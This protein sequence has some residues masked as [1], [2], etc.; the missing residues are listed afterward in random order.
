MLNRYSLAPQPNPAP[1]RSSGKTRIGGFAFVVGIL[2]STHVAAQT[3][4]GF[5]LDFD[6]EA[7]PWE[8]IA[9]QLPA[10]PTPD[11]LLPFDAGPTATQSF[12]IDAKSLT[13]DAD[14]VIRYTLVSTSAGGAKNIS[15]EGIRCRSFEKKVYAFGQPDGTWSRSRRNQWEPIPR[16]V[17]NVQ[18]ESLALDYFCRSTMVADSPAKILEKIRNTSLNRLKSP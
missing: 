14:D 9:P 5:G 16:G 15:Y 4:P 11:S 12:A 18:H 17:A 8:E 3:M 10:A 7:K 1:T 2:L 6:D 13:V